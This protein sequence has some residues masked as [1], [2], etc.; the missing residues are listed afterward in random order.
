MSAMQSWLFGVLCF[1]ASAL[2]SVAADLD[3]I[4]ALSLIHI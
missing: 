2:P 4:K 3:E 1:A